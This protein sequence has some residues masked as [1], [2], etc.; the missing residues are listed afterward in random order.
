MNGLNASFMPGQYAKCSMRSSVRLHTLQLLLPLSG[1]IRRTSM[2]LC[3][4]HLNQEW[5]S[6]V[7]ARGEWMSSP[8]ASKGIVR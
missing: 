6:F 4:I 3:K 5:M 8:M 7:V 1:L 2:P